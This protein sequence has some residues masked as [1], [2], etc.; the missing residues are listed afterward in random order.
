MKE[1]MKVD[2]A[3]LNLMIP[4]YCFFNYLIP[5]DLINIGSDFSTP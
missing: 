1:K 3:R 2:E 4:G 5:R